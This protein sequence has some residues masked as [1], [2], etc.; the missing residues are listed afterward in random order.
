ITKITCEGSRAS[1]TTEPTLETVH[2]ANPFSSTSPC[3][4]FHCR[5]LGE[6]AQCFPIIVH[7][8]L[9]I[10][11]HIRTLSV[12]CLLLFFSVPFFF[13]GR[14]HQAAPPPAYGNHSRP[15]PP[16]YEDDSDVDD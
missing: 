8:S 12:V 2:F 4:I 9:C 1:G 16:A 5:K 13:F 3:D 14:F 10:Y 11:M 15:P 6:T 7:L